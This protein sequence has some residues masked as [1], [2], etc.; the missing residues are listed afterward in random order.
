MRQEQKWVLAIAAAAL[1]TASLGA[2]AQ[3]QSFDSRW[4]LAP[5]Y[6]YAWPDSNEGTNN[7]SGWQLD[8]GKPL[9]EQWN[10]EFGVINYDLDF[11]NGIP[12][13]FHQTEYGLNGLWFFNDRPKAFAPFVSL[14]AGANNQKVS[15]AG[16]N[17]KGYGTVGIGFLTSPWSW[18]G[19]IR[20][21]VQEV[22]TFG[23][24]N[25]NDTVASI[26]LQIPLGAAPE[27]APPP[28]PPPPP[29]A[30]APAPQ[31]PPPP[32]PVPAPAP[33]PAPP[34]APAPQEIISLPG[35][36]FAH[37][38]AVLTPSSR[39]TLDNAVQTLK[40]N[41]HINAEVAGYTSST[42]TA[43]YNLKLSQRRAESVMKYLV[44][45][46]ID[47]GR[48]TAKGY[49]EADPVASNKTA[50]GRAKNRRVELRVTNQ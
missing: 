10:L 22:H 44:G 15:G 7:G 8:F 16:S 33:A 50:A 3:D 31:P 1:V 17:T 37:N 13:S 48:L 49:G 21:S 43:A 6:S 32:A 19:A 28:P 34:P 11:K 18:G 2:S 42:G 12:G 29:P 36:D 14:G 20:F 5:Q 39:G 30:P 38:S 24:G 40:N 46:G 25:F 41:M 35:V 23:N 4:Y 26:G 27:A 9:S 47:A 45:H